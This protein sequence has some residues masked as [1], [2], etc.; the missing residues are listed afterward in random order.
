MVKIRYLH[1]VHIALIVLTFWVIS[2]A[3]SAD[4]S[5]KF[6]NTFFPASDSILSYEQAEELWGT[7]NFSAIQSGISGALNL[8]V[9]EDTLFW[10]YL[11]PEIYE[12]QLAFLNGGY[13]SVT[14]SEFAGY[15]DSLKQSYISQYP[16][17][18]NNMP[19]FIEQVAQQIAANSTAQTVN[20]AC[21]NMGF[22]N[23]TTSGWTTYSGTACGAANLLPCNLTAGTNARVTI[24]TAGSTDPFI[25]SLS[26]VAP[27]AAYSLMLEDY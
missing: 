22:E 10:R 26:T 6:N 12:D 23:G 16:D 11:Q 14:I 19:V 15:V 1:I 7:L 2:A 3:Y 5:S 18:V 21:T 24:T 25:P 4:N 17:F 9:A 27:G 13:R 8:S 20:P